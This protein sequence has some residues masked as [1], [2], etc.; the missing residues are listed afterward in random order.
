MKKSLFVFL[1]VLLAVPAA[2][3]AQSNV[4]LES[5]IMIERVVVE[6]GKREVKVE[7][8]KVVVPGDRLVFVISYQNQGA[9]PA[10]DFVVTNPLPPSVT[11][12]AAEGDEAVVSVDGGKSYGQL[13]ALKVK[14]PDGTD[15]DALPADVTHIRWAF[16]R[17]IPAGAAGTLRFKGV[18]K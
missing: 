5:E 17:P 18:V 2:A 8:P 13:A 11:F 1:S 15:R 9:A 10:T 7:V 12:E 16:A 14:Q 6:D 3:A 4:S